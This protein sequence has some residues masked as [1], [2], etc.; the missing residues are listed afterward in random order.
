MKEKKKK[1]YKAIHQS[2]S[3]LGG[4]TVY[5][6]DDHFL[7]ACNKGYTEQYYRFFYKD[8]IALKVLIGKWANAMLIALI[9]LSFV[10]LGLAFLTYE[11]LPLATVS[12]IICGVFVVS[13]IWVFISGPQTKL[14]IKTVSTEQQFSLG[15]RDKVMHLV[16]QMRPYIKKAQM[17]YDSENFEWE[18]RQSE[19]KYKV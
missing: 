18:I 12:G 5:V 17:E 14:T 7:I 16:K 4:N 6:S 8:I 11:L 1:D 15:R 2:R 19:Q 9:I 10:F 3:S 13:S